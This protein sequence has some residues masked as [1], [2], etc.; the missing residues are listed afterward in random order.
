MGRIDLGAAG[1]RRA[2]ARIVYA[3]GGQA[4][5]AKGLVRPAM[6]KSAAYALTSRADE[7]T[8]TGRCGTATQPRSMVSNASG[9]SG[10]LH[11]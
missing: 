3:H 4:R 9:V 10:R 8:R 1:A 7:C 6:P 2:A 5:C 11:R